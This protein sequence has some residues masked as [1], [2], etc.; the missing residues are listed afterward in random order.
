MYTRHE[1]IR[2]L[3]D[4]TIARFKKLNKPN[5][6]DYQFFCEVMGDTAVRREAFLCFLHDVSTCPPDVI[7]WCQRQI[8][9][10][11]LRMVK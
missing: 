11:R 7:Q 8:N 3:F 9:Q 10:N 2:K 6:R 4:E 5:Y 1:E